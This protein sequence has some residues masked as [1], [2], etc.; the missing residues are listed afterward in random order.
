MDQ[1][2]KKMLKVVTI[3]DVIVALVI[4]TLIL[5]IVNYN[6]SLILLF[7][8]ATA[9]FNFFLSTVTADFVVAKQAGNKMLIVISSA[10]RVILVCAISILLYKLYK[11]YLIA[12]I[13]GYS[14][15]FI[16]LI[17]YGLLLKNE[18]RK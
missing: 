17:I 5:I 14:A 9:V 2:I 1:N 8:I 10:F 7:G 6:Y 16:A 11:Y 15:H 18:E 12:Y 3:C 13:A 4:C